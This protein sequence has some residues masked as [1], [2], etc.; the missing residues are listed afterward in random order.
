MNSLKCP[1]CPAEVPVPEVSSAGGVTLDDSYVNEHVEMHTTC[2]CLWNG[3]VGQRTIT[4]T[5]ETCPNHGS[6]RPL[7]AP[8]PDAILFPDLLTDEDVE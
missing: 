5:D 2:T 1:V 7:S 6:V 4:A 3:E 8:T